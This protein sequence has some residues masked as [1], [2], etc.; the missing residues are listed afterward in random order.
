MLS[1]VTD[2]AFHSALEERIPRHSQHI[3]RPCKA[4]LD[5]D[6]MDDTCRVPSDEGQ[7]RALSKIIHVS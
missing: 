2:R 1:S 5:V 3:S 4:A 7:Q 6:K